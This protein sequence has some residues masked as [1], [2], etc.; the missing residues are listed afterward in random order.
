MPIMDGYEATRRIKASA[1]ESKPIIIALTAS[2][3]AEQRANILEA[4]CDDF[5]SKPCPQ[6]VIFNKLAEHL[7]VTYLYEEDSLTNPISQLSCL[8][9]P[10]LQVMTSEWIEALHQAAIQVDADLVKLLIAQIPL[11]YPNL[12]QK[13]TELTNQYNFDEII[14]LTQ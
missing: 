13:L 5:V 8:S 11:N 9:Y 1:T 7:G 4:G 3:F 6:E 14:E 10:D 12:A 2:A